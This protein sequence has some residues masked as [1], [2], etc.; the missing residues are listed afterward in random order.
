METAV[1]YGGT[2]KDIGSH[3]DDKWNRTVRFRL[4]NRLQ[5]ARIVQKT[6]LGTC[7][8]EAS[9]ES[10]ERYDT[11]GVSIDVLEDSSLASFLPSDRMVLI[12]P[13]RSS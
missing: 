3:V 2:V 12:P 5:F 6:G 11:K 13:E 7:A 4:G 1:E 10:V 9:S 8:F